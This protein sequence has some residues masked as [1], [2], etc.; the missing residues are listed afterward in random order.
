MNPNYNYDFRTL[1][2][3][4]VYLVLCISEKSA[5]I[6]SNIQ[7]QIKKLT[8]ASMSMPAL[9]ATRKAA[10]IASKRSFAKYFHE[11][12][13]NYI[14]KSV[15]SDILTAI[16]DGKGHRQ[17]NSPYHERQFYRMRVSE[18]KNLGYYLV[19]HGIDNTFIEELKIKTMFSEYLALARDCQEPQTI[20]KRSK[21]N[22]KD[23][24]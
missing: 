2:K 23:N 8:I 12:V 21:E 19:R 18:V 6:E 11:I 7:K 15:Y 1:S 10:N 16:V 5:D 24:H 4:N 20:N 22:D 17:L 14:D 9:E 3:E 13:H